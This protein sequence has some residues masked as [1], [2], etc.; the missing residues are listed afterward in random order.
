MEHAKLLLAERAVSVTKIGLTVGFSSP[1]AFATAFRKAT[2]L[3]PTDYRRSFA[4]GPAMTPQCPVDRCR[5][6]RDRRLV[7][8]ASAARRGARQRACSA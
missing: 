3:T 8:A 5:V 1:N 6:E 4:S 2:G 7:G